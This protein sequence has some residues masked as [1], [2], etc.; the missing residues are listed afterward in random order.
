[1]YGREV[2]DPVPPKKPFARHPFFWVLTSYFAEGYPYSIV[3]NLADVM[4]KEM[5]ASLQA[6]GLTS[7][8]HLPWNLK[9]AW[10][11]FLDAYGTK[12]QWI[13]LCEVVIAALLIALAFSM[14]STNVLAAAS[15]VFVL[16][17]FASA[18]HDIAIDGFYME[19]LDERGQS[20]YVGIRAAAYRAATAGVLAGGPILA[21]L[22][23]WSSTW[24]AA[25]LL[26]LGLLAFHQW[27][28]PR[29]ERPR[30]PLRVL[31]A[32]APRFRILMLGTLVATVIAVE[33]E[34]HVLAPVWRAVAESVSAIPGLGKLSLAQWIGLVLL[35]SLLAVLASLG[36][37]RKAIASKDSDFAR[38]F[39]DFL[40]Q[41][42]IGRILA[43]ILLFRTG[44]S[45][46]QKMRYP[47]FDDEVQLGLKA[48]G[49]LNGAG[50]LV[51]M[52]G[53]VIGGFLIARYGLRRCVWPFVLAQNVLNLL[54][55]GL[56]MAPD[57]AATPRP[58]VAAVILVEHLGAGLGTAGFMVYIMRCCDP[59]H[60]AAH[61]AIVTA[62]MSVGFTLAG[63]ASGF[64]ADAMGYTVYFGFTFVATIPSM[65]LLP[66]VPH[67]DGREGAVD[68]TGHERP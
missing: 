61:M 6:I 16:L 68:P 59:R 7:L 43:F 51:G 5:G 30:K 2:T 20:R 60:K 56:A 4:F 58:V 1:M 10:G 29:V 62:L 27:A 39:V 37:V 52:V 13:L 66:F 31:V 38:A 67:L 55:M 25:M 21:G 19:A 45:F 11:P 65:A 48:Y 63:V 15:V 17:A 33:R 42:H 54:Y 24:I 26:M 14:T 40:D 36:R 46:L 47:F 12:R 9:F 53:T 32:R 64:L 3:V 28:L 23:G 49:A 8:F 50:F 22:F 57:P 34:T 18:T 41:R 44:E 35:V